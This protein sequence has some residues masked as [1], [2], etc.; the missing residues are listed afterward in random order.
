MARSGRSVRRA[1]AALCL[2]LPFVGLLWPPWYAHEEPHL[3]GVPF[4]YWYQFAWVPVSVVL[5]VVAARLLRGPAEHSE[6][7]Q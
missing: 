5:M 6:V 2:A 1:A 7:Q 3:G 4:F